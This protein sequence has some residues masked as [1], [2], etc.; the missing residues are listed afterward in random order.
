[1]KS[2]T[3]LTFIGVEIAIFALASLLHRGII[4][5]G[6]EH[7]KAATAEFVIA[8]VLATGLGYSLYQPRAI[9][10]AA[11]WVQ[12]IALLGVCVG[13]AMILIGVGPRTPL[14]FG[15]HAVMLIVL[16]SGLVA[17]RSTPQ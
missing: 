14:D 8:V 7:A 11:L 5:S 15:I 17:A 2:S 1:M 16:I 4:Y 9:C 6:Y 3:T 12:G 13:I 10:A